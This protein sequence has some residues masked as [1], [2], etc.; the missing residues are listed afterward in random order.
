VYR[1]AGTYDLRGKLVVR[2]G[3]GWEPSATAPA[4]EY[5]V[6]SRVMLAAVFGPHNRVGSSVDKRLQKCN[7]LC[8]FGDVDKHDRHTVVAV[9]IY[10]GA[11]PCLRRVTPDGPCRCHP[12]KMSAKSLS[13]PRRVIRRAVEATATHSLSVFHAL[14]Q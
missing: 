5:D 8:T 3:A 12:V 14:A 1:A 2:G 11:G 13:M 10:S 4:T 7:V 6:V 9:S